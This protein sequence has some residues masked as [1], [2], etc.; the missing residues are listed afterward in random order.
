MTLIFFIGGGL[1]FL[2]LV[3]GA[4]ISLAGLV[5]SRVIG[6]GSAGVLVEES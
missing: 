5:V 4:V 2:L 6:T 1:I 3:A